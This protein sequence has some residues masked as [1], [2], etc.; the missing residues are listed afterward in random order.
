MRVFNEEDMVVMA[1]SNIDDSNF[2][3]FLKGFAALLVAAHKSEE[4]APMRDIEMF[5]KGLIAKSKGGMNKWLPRSV[6]DHAV[7]VMA[8]Y[9]SGKLDAVLEEAHEALYEKRQDI[10][11]DNTLS[12]NQ[13]KIFSSLWGYLTS[14]ED[15]QHKRLAKLEADIGLLKDPTLNA[16]H[17]KNQEK[18]DQA[19]HLKELKFLLKKK[20]YSTDPEENPMLTIKGDDLKK[21]PKA[22]KTRYTQLRSNISNAYK[23]AL[24]DYVRST[25]KPT[26]RVSKAI[27]E[28]KNKGVV[29][30]SLPHG[31]DGR[32]DE[33]GR[34]HTHHNEEITNLPMPGSK[35]EMNPDYRPGTGGAVFKYLP[36][37]TTDKE[38][39]WQYAY[40]NTHVKEG[41]VDK[42][43]K[44]TS[45]MTPE[46]MERARK[47][48][49]RDIIGSNKRKAALGLVMELLLNHQMRIGSSQGSTDGKDT[50][51]LLTLK[52][53][54]VNVK[55]TMIKLS[56]PGKSGMTQRHIMRGTDKVSKLVIAKMAVLLKNKKAN[57]DFWEVG[58]KTLTYPEVKNY[59][60]SLGLKINPKDFRTWKADTMM[61]EELDN[62]PFKAPKGAS[63]AQVQKAAN[64]YY[65]KLAMKVGEQLGHKRTDK[66]GKEVL[67]DATALKSYINPRIGQDFF[68][69]HGLIVPNFIPH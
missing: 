54:N 1:S 6:W 37:K 5:I 55:G 15:N 16:W 53:K 52:A 32:V 63:P 2:N 45:T 25:G 10:L 35:I 18:S 22:Q 51:G 11:R 19:E 39:S 20:G 34:L 61:N 13:R 21:L 4:Q 33:R 9:K 36:P 50:Y 44:R 56:Y 68:K 67:T 31:F 14:N 47:R 64:E 38:P 24:R 17:M 23:T 65:R 49:L 46:A 62:E 28:M 41:R 29:I 43:L 48:W 59:I 40:T 27:K 58:D 57:D 26:V 60:R 30:H 8:N 3:Y 66:T 7:R 42:K 12:D 69:K